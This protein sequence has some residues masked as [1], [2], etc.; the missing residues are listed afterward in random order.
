MLKKKK[1]KTASYGNNQ[2]NPDMKDLKVNFF[3]QI[4]L[5]RLTKAG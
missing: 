2:Q 3:E 5:K 4:D 1:K